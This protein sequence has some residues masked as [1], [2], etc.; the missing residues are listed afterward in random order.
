MWTT[1]MGNDELGRC[2][3]T[4]RTESAGISNNKREVD[5]T[6]L[7]FHLEWGDITQKLEFYEMNCD[8]S[9]SNLD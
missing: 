9:A 1:L 7:R 8:K 4:L 5:A 2:E 6:E 3:F